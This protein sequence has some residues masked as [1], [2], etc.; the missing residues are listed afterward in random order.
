MSVNKIIRGGNAHYEQ[1]DGEAD[2][3]L[4]PGEL[5]EGESS[6]A[7]HATDG[8]PASAEFVRARKGLGDTIQDDVPSGEYCRVA[9]CAPG[10]K[11]YGF[12][13]AGESV[14][15]GDFLVSNGDGS[16]RAYDA[17]GGDTPGMVVGKATEDADLS[18]ASER[19]RVNL[20]VV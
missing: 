20:R 10:V 15:E 18:G 3:A 1:L 16:L 2:E 19:G 9:Q 11:V 7:A 13:A 17:A 4:T 14:T 8:G 6:F 12:L 5:V